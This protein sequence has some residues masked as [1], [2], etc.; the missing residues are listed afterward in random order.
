M[1]KNSTLYNFTLILVFSSIRNIQQ[2]TW[3]CWVCA[4]P[5]PREA[6][7]VA[8]RI[9]ALLFLNSEN[10]QLWTMHYCCKFSAKWFFSPKGFLISVKYCIMSKL[11]LI[12]LTV[13][14]GIFLIY[15]ALFHGSHS[16]Q[17]AN[18]QFCVFPVC[19]FK[20]FYI[21]HVFPVWNYKFSP[22]SENTVFKKFGEWWV[23]YLEEPSLSPA[24]ICHHGYKLLANH[25]A[26]FSVSNHQLYALFQQRWES[27]GLFPCLYLATAS[28]TCKPKSVHTS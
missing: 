1:S 19:F 13:F 4:L 16:I 7:S 25:H 21:P 17:K 26:S 5:R 6:T 8:T 9:G 3:V 18:S 23:H 10:R 28:A 15:K 27:Y 20:Q 12:R 11:R 2:W 14:I 22:W 24:E